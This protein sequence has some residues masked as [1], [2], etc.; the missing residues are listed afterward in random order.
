MYRPSLRPHPGRLNG[1]RAPRHPTAWEAMSRTERLTGTHP[2][3]TSVSLVGGSCYCRVESI[4]TIFLLFLPTEP[5]EPAV[6]AAGSAGPWR[7][8]DAP[9][10]YL[11]IRRVNR[12]NRL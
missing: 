4:S 8:A 12:G 5:R 1:T 9:R 11:R 2:R 7:A 6:P 10:T 3:G